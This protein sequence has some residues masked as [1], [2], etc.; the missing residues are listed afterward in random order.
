ME[1]LIQQ[2]ESMLD[3]SEPTDKEYC[4]SVYQAL[5]TAHVANETRKLRH[6]FELHHLNVGN[7][8][9]CVQHRD[10]AEPAGHEKCKSCGKGI[11][12]VCSA[13]HCY[14]PTVN[15]ESTVQV[16]ISQ[17]QHDP[18]CVAGHGHLSS[19]FN[20]SG[21][22]LN[23]KEPVDVPASVHCVTERPANQFTC[24]HHI[25]TANAKYI[26]TCDL[27]GKVVD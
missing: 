27:C 13:C 15:V 14:C 9:Y 2:L 26:T 4:V 24:D 11:G 3:A 18:A 16:G 7:Q 6:H 5:A 25:Q 1:S 19:C 20:A 23:Y 8:S 10:C 17:C 21:Q 22:F 12:G